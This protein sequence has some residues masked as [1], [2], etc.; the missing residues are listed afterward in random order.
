M[1]LVPIFFSVIFRWRRWRLRA[2]EDVILLKFAART[3]ALF[4]AIMEDRIS[5]QVR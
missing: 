4:F 2:E 1:G 3:A 5:K